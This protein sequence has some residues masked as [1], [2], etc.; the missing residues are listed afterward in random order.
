MQNYIW[1]IKTKHYSKENK[2]WLIDLLAKNRGLIAKNQLKEF[3]NPTIDQILKVKL[4]DTQKAIARV[5]KAIKSKE[6]I[7]VYSDYDADGICG[8][9]IMWETLFDLGAQ[10]LPYVPHRINEG[11]GFYIPAIEKLAADGVNLIISVDHGVTAVK[12]IERA[13]KLGIDVIITDH[14]LLPKE[15]PQSYALVHSLDLCGAGVAWR[16]CYDLVAKIKPSYKQNLIDKLELAAIAT[17]ADLVPLT[18]ANRTIV[19]F[20][21]EILNLRSRPGIESLLK[22]AGIDGQI[23]SF[24]IGHILAPRINAMGRIEHGLDALRLICAKSR[25]SADTLA[26]LLSKTNTRRQDLT[27]SAVSEAIDLVIE[28]HL[29]GVVSSA[30]WHE[31]VIGLVASRLVEAHHR[32]MIVISRGQAYSK[33]SARSIP[34]F[35]IV[36]AIRA[37]SE[38]LVDAG[39]HPMAAGFTIETRYIETFI[40]KINAYAAGVLTDDLLQPVINIECELERND[41]NI[42]TLNLIKTF[43]PYGVGNPLPTFLTRQMLVEDVRGVGQNSRH[44]KLQVDGM[45]CI[46]FNMGEMRMMLRPGYLADIVYTLD[47]NRYNGSSSLQMK[48]K[49]LKTV[50]R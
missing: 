2:N 48:I 7:I 12:Q 28:D 3:L 23:G 19:K 46:W 25:K 4:T 1:K 45:S 49:D 15:V 36:D 44:L 37:S 17:I 13:K 38:Y 35:N 32:P 18:G 27:T 47:E 5:D 20:G 34:G 33:G 21:L 16:F 22:D 14:H 41:I 50:Q 40:K 29:V 24:E 9:A 26:K 31:G 11:Y 8:S 43:E 42:Q 10:V 39:G 30:N 6:K